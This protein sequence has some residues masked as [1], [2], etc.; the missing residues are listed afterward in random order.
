[1]YVNGSLV[2]TDTSGAVPISPSAVYIGSE[3]GS[4]FAGF[5]MKSAIHWK[6]VLTNDQL[7]ALTGTSFNTYA[8]M[9]SYYNYTLQ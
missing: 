8:E 5:K 9:A 3:S 7:E 4:S 6:E 1:L 2:G